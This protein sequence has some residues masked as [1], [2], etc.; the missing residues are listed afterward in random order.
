MSASL[1][2]VEF[3]G[4]TLYVINQDGLPFVPMRAVVE[5]MGLAWPSQHTKLTSNAL[6]WGVTE[7]VTPSRSGD[8]AMTCIPLHKVAGWLS[9]ISPNKV[10]PELREKVIKYQN[11]CDTALFDYWTKGLAVRPVECISPAQKL[12]I[13]DVIHSCHIKTGEPHQ[14]IYHRFYKQFNISAYAELVASEYAAAIAYLG[15]A[16]VARQ[17]RTV[18]DTIDLLTVQVK[19][20]NGYPLQL[21]RP[22]YVALHGRFRS[23]SAITVDVTKLAGIWQDLGKLRERVNGLGAM[24]DDLP[25]AWWEERKLA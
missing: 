4:N 2:P 15:G 16:T 21:L 11:E 19:Q 14:S 3:A 24:D 9:T 10:K 25:P 23:P 13:R 1:L 8:Q 22:L 20:P 17:D 7:I 6:R 18:Q 5:G 12:A